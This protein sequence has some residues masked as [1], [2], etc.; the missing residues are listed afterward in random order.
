MI[1]ALPPTASL[2]VDDDVSRDEE[3]FD[4]APL[5][6]VFFALCLFGAC[7]LPELWLLLM[8]PSNDDDPVVPLKAP[9]PPLPAVPP[10]ICIRFDL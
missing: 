4:A 10:S 6:G 8:L 9:H 1:F 7:R 3:V 2:P 5:L